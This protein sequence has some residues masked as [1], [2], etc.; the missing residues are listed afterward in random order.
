[1][2]HPRVGPRVKHTRRDNEHFQANETHLG[3]NLKWNNT[4]K[5]SMEASMDHFGGR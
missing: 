2:S 4:A 3:E 1:M 5:A